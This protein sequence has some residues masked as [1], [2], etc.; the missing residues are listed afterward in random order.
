MHQLSPLK[1]DSPVRIISTAGVIDPIWLEG[2]ARCLTQWGLRVQTGKNASKRCGRFAGTLQERLEDLQEALDDPNIEAIFFSRG[3]YGTVHV[4]DKLR[5]DRFRAK[6][7]WLIGF[8]DI[9]MLHSLIQKQGVESIHG[10]MAKAL[11]ESLTQ[12]NEPMTRLKNLLFGLRDDVITSVHPLNKMGVAKGR[13]VGGNLSI[14]YS[15]R[16]TPFDAEFKNN[17]LFIE[18]IGEKPYVIDRM[19]YNLKL[20]GALAQ[21]SGLVVGQ[22]NEYEEDPLF[23]K[24]VYEIVA[25]A[26]AEYHYPI[27]FNFPIGHV[28]NN[29]P[30]ICGADVRLDVGTQNTNLHYLL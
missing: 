5:L 15:L 9:T 17:I 8:S 23:G 4:L 11:T 10:G 24:T 16:A 25:S 27:A 21:L 20:S 7:K 12:A 26:V 1:K 14:L 3:G 6:P 19:M 2:A 13:L 29:Q 28:E 30:L 18:D 22:F